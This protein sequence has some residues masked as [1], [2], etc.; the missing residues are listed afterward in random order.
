MLDET[1]RKSHRHDILI[2]TGDFNA[3]VGTYPKHYD[4]VMGKHGEDEKK[5]LKQDKKN[6]LEAKAKEA[7]EAARNQHTKTLYS[8]VKTLTNERPRKSTAI[9]DKENNIITNS[10][11]RKKR[12]KEHFNEILNR[13]EPVNPVCEEEAPV[14]EIDSIST[15]PPTLEEINK[16]LKSLKNGK[17]AGV[18]SIHQTQSLHLVRLNN[19]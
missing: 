6:W 4:S 2:V 19:C 16:T 15:D 14:E 9:K 12:W 13:N 8:I 18:D 11:D 7:E 17:A 5:Q 1:V 10:E 3:K